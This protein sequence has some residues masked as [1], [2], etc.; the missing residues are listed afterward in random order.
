MIVVAEVVVVVAVICRRGA[1]VPGDLWY[2]LAGFRVGGLPG[3]QILNSYCFVSF[4]AVCCDTGLLRRGR[5][6]FLSSRCACF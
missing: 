3:V 4:F 1:R 6:C 5:N 2:C